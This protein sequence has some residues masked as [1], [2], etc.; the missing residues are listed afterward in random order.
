MAVYRAHSAQDYVAAAEAELQAHRL[1]QE[2]GRCAACGASAPCE[3]ANAAFAELVRYGI[4]TAA[5]WSGDPAVV[6]R[7][8]GE[9]RWVRQ[10]PLMTL[11]AWRRTSPPGRTPRVASG[12]ALRHQH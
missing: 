10:A 11:L 5:D 7:T 12:A 2:S 9:G 1:D 3:P 8:P 6:S 4:T